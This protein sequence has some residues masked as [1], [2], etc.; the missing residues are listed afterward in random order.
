MA[1][2]SPG[3]RGKE[4][5]LASCPTST[6]IQ[7]K[8]L[9][10]EEAKNHCLHDQMCPYKCPNHASDQWG[11]LDA[12]EEGKVPKAKPPHLCQRPLDQAGCKSRDVH[13]WQGPEGESQQ[14]N[15][16]DRPPQYFSEN[17]PHTKIEPVL[18]D[19]FSPPSINFSQPKKN[20]SSKPN[21]VNTKLLIK[22]KIAKGVVIREPS[23]NTSRPIADDVV[24][25]DNEKAV[26]PPS[27]VKPSSSHP[28]SFSRTTQP[29][30][31]LG[32]KKTSSDTRASPVKKKN[33]LLLW[34]P[35]S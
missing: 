20:P 1:V 4:G 18:S 13:K 7:L 15:P 30:P 24:G 32:E 28:I 29:G 17:L 11:A 23:P 16:Q 26:E 27:K 14:V 6:N 22:A 12:M 9:V 8:H 21:V 33:V 25:K 10:K 34:T 5:F 31:S 19:D 3:N 2:T 35:S